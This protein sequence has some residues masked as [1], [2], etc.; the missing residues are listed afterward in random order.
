MAENHFGRLNNKA[1]QTN[2]TLLW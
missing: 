2:D 1:G